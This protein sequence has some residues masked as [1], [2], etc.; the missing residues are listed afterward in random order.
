MARPSSLNLAKK[1]ILT[2]FS[3]ASNKVYSEAE[4]ARVLR[5]Q[6]H[7]WKL[8]ASTRPSD[9]ITF[10][11]KHGDLKKQQ[12]RSDHYN[13][14]ITRYTW[15]KASLYELALSIKQ[16]SYLCHATAVALHGL[17]KVDRK[18]IYLNAEQSIKPSS[19]GSLTQGG[20]YRAFSGKQ[21][22]SNLIY[23]LNTNS[24]TMIA[25]KNTNRLGVEEIAGPASE[26]ISVT[27]LERTL[28]DIVVR[29][30]YAGGT[31]AI[32]KAYRA[33]KNRIS[34]NRL[35]SILNKLDYVYPYHQ[36]IGFLMQEAGYSDSALHELRALGLKYDFY[37]GHGL[38]EPKYSKEW[39]LFYP[40]DLK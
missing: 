6:R 16:H 13:R 17:T 33:A 40:N 22:Q 20:I 37:L 2:W 27:N 5:D 23:T 34:F 30:A 11:D 12:F 39:R 35:I 7:D 19:G 10:L 14:K 25:G 31:T 3:E 18:R 29:P 21:R 15:G 1:E 9:F 8:A 32:L 36:P 28:I 4:I 24:I 26:N 38:Q